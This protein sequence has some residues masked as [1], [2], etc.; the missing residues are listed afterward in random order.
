MGLNIRE[1][2]SNDA[3]DLSALAMISKAYWGY[4]DA[5]MEACRKGLN[6]YEDYIASK[7]VQFWLA[8]LPTI[9]I[10]ELTNKPRAFIDGF[11]AIHFGENNKAMI[12]ALFVHPQSMK[13]GIARS[14]F[15]KALSEA[16]AKGVT[17]FHVQSDPNAEIFYQQ[18]GFKTYEMH[19]SGS[20]KERTLPMM[21]MHLNQTNF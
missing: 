10:K 11:I 8:W 15:Q 21:K 2:R 19:A 4:D 1:A 16:R 17:E 14:L 18:L 13:K 20:I 7:N 3:R 9:E 12:E 5:F 6:Y